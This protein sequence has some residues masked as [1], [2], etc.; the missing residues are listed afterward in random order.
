[1]RKI[2]AVAAF[3]AACTAALACAAGASAYPW[4]VKPFNRP[5]PVRANFGDPRTIFSISPAG[6]GLFGPGQFSFHSGVDISAP[7]GTPVYAVMSGTAYAVNREQVNVDVAPGLTF[8]YVHIDPVLYPAHPAIAGKTIL[9]YVQK[10]A[11]HVHLTEIRDGQ[12]TNP[13]LKGHLTPYYDQTR[14]RVT[15]IDV[16]DPQGQSMGMLGVHGTVELVAQAYDTPQIPAPGA[17]RSMP[18]APAIVQWR[19]ARTVNNR[20]T[21]PTRTVVDF[22]TGLPL[23]RDFWNVYA[24]GTY[25]NQPRFGPT[26]YSWMPGQFIFN[27]TPTLLDTRALRPGPYTLTVTAIDIRGHRGSLQQRFFV[28][29]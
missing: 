16:R 19:L 23:P 28:R 1:M 14:P 12:V 29:N 8:Q 18:V 20:I 27:L 25:Q 3:A 5:H 2:T 4:P 7:G 10:A 9:G 13:L 17:W 26:I 15:S 11:G 22:T 21:I 6:A 24:R